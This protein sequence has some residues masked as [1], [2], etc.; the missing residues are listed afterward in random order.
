MYCILPSLDRKGLEIILQ[1]AAGMGLL[2]IFRMIFQYPAVRQL[3]PDMISKIA[4]KAAVGG[5][6]NIIKM[7]LQFRNTLNLRS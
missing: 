2:D 1:L 6:P 5:N 7:V 4:I 3:I